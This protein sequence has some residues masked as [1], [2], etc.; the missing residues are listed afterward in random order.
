[1]A[2]G[3][4][5]ADVPPTRGVFK[6]VSA[7]RSELSVAVRVG[8]TGQSQSMTAHEVPTH[9]PW[10]SREVPIVACHGRTSLSSNSSSSKTSRSQQIRSAVIHDRRY[11]LSS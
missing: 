8:T 9:M 7:V 2:I 4:D 5:Y 3:R 10:V 1:M 6:G 11:L